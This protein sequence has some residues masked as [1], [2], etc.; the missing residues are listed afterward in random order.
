MNID[1]LS[2][3][4]APCLYTELLKSTQTG[5]RHTLPLHQI[6]GS[7][8]VLDMVKIRENMSILDR[9]QRESG[10]EVLLALKG[11]STYCAFDEM[12]PYLAGCCASGLWEARLAREKFGKQ[13][14]T[15]SPAF[16]DSVIDS[17]IGYSDHI[18]F[19][20]LSQWN[21]YRN[22]CREKKSLKCGLRIN[23]ECSTGRVPLY[24]PCAP[25]SRLGVRAE[26]L[27]LAGEKVWKGISGLHC[28]T[29]CQQT[30]EPLELTLRRIEEKFGA[31]LGRLE[32]FNFGGGHHITREDY[33]VDH[34]ISLVKEFS[35]R[36]Q[37]KVYL[38]PGEAHVLDAGCLVAS[39]L[40]VIHNG[41]D[42]AI[43]D[44][45]ATSHMPDVL[46]MPYRPPVTNSGNPGEFR[47]TYRLGSPSCLSGDIIGDYSFKKPLKVGDRIVFEDQ[48]QY[49]MVKTTN[50]NGIQHPSIAMWDSETGHYE[51]SRQFT[52]D[53]FVSRLG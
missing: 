22:I 46:E 1:I 44:V 49:T 43:L 4:S 25:F 3:E 50:F 7:T 18:T 37:L 13:V 48:A 15:Y 23:P 24:D 40:D 14:H 36:W 41:M 45:S 5:R 2:P 34:L 11:F 53:D 39:V 19:N 20:S 16:S 6:E 28:H 30:T 17:I 12:R 32:W 21:R 33:D 29:L 26:E 42:I 51:V 47:Y 9:V 38:E 52:Y 31:W 8:Y 10:C 35:E 27:A